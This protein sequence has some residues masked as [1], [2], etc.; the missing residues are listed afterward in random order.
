[1]AI[2]FLMVLVLGQAIFQVVRMAMESL[3]VEV[4]RAGSLDVGKDG[5][6]DLG[7]GGGGSGGGCGSV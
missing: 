5:Y 2:E 7:C 3:K 6:G 4:A 1:M